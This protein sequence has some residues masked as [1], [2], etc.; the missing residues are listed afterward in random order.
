MAAQLL[1]Q[2]T[3]GNMNFLNNGTNKL[4]NPLIDKAIENTK[5]ITEKVVE[6]NEIKNPLI[7]SNILMI[8]KYANKHSELFS[9]FKTN[10]KELFNIEWNI[11][12]L[13]YSYN[14]YIND[15][16]DII[17]KNSELAVNYQKILNDKW[18]TDFSEAL[19]RIWW[20]N[21]F[22]HIDYLNIH[23]DLWKWIYVFYNILNKVFK[24]I[25]EWNTSGTISINVEVKDIENENF[26]KIIKTLKEKYNIDLSKQKIIFEILENEKLPNTQ[27]F[28]EKIVKLKNH[29]F[30]IALDDILS[31]K[32]TLEDVI[33]SLNYAWN[34]LDMIKI[35]W[36]MLQSF[37]S[38]YKTAYSIFGKWFLELK[39]IFSKISNRW[40]K[41]VAEWIEDM[42]MLHFA[43][44]ILWIKYF[45][46][47]F[48]NKEENIKILQANSQI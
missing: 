31:E 42:D 37:Y 11:I 33:K 8:I 27:E 20:I 23:N 36:K 6:L 15:F 16:F 40:V 5:S 30:D 18:N 29:W 24:D 19:L 47:F 7:K 26:F 4:L 48:S 38:I 10:Y 13:K 46:W 35:D 45:Q 28:K 39:Q 25:S 3:F 1:T 22:N 32:V 34:N 44:N 14:K 17:Y 12:R 9:E 2:D 41:I 43:K 21:G